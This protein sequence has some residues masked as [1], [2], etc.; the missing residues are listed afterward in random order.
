LES[1][2][3]DPG[4][5]VND[6]HRERVGA[7]SRQIRR[8][9]RKSSAAWIEIDACSAAVQQPKERRGAMS[10]GKKASPSDWGKEETGNIW[11]AHH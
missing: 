8:D 6:W 5:T 7:L 10:T 3:V 4:R 11:K 2:R 1:A 9:G